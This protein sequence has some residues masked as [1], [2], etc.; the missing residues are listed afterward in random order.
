MFK[1]TRKIASALAMGATLALAGNAAQAAVLYQ[2]DNTT[3]DIIPGLTG[4]STSGAMMSGMSVTAIFSNGT[5]QTLSWATTGA[6]SGGVTGT[7]WG[8][9]MA[10]DSFSAEWLF[11][12][13]GQANLGQI[14][15][16]RLDG[17]PGL[18][19]FDRT[20][21][22]FGTDGSAS[23]RDFVF[24]SGFDAV[25]TDATVTYSNPV[26]IS[27]NAAVGD[28]FNIV[29]VDFRDS[30]GVLTGPRANFSF[31][32][33]TDNDSRF[34]STIPEPASLALMGLGLMG[35]AAVR[36]RTKHA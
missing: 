17:R 4:F 29:E 22:S 14:V 32:Q 20:D 8:L 13:D 2:V 33:D 23:G 27:P 16:L 25:N 7:G 12:I 5:N 24:V 36:R 21:P 10:G 11:T 3:T 26:A 9:S 34:G 28:L 15:T 18:T 1:Q 31:R 6:S 19:V 35:L 30:E